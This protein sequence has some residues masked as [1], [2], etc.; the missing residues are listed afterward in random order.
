[1]RPDT[2]TDSL[3]TSG[4][5][6]AVS[7]PVRKAGRECVIRP[8]VHELITAGAEGRLT[9]ISAP[10]GAGKT[11]ALRSW[12][13]SGEYQGTVV[14]LT[15]SPTP[16]D[17]WRDLGAVTATAVGIPALEDDLPDDVIAWTLQGLLSG[18]PEPVLYA[19]DDLHLLGYGPELRLLGDF[20]SRVP[21]TVSI[22]FTCRRD[23]DLAL[24]R[25]RMYGELSEIRARELA[26]T[27]DEAAELFT[28]SGLHVEEAHVAAL[29]E[30]TEGWAAGL[31]F[32]AL[33]IKE[34]DDL[35][36]FI[37]KFGR[38]EGVVAEFL[39]DEVLARLS[40]EMRAFLFITAQPD[41]I[42][43]E[44]ADAMTGRTDSADILALLERENVFL[45]HL[46]E[47]GWYRY[48]ALFAA[49]LRADGRVHAPA[50]VKASHA[51]AARWLVEHGMLLAAAGH[52]IAAGDPDL[53]EH[54]VSSLWS[55][56]IGQDARATADDLLASIPGDSIGDRPNLALLAGW[57]R[58]ASGQLGEADAWFEIADKKGLDLPGYEFA[59]AL[60]SLAR[61]R[62]VGDVAGIDDA[63]SELESS[64]SI[65]RWGD[66][67]RRR[68]IV[69]CAR[70]AAAIWRNDFQLGIALLE[71]AL[72]DAR[73]LGLAGCEADASGMLAL[74]YALRG[75]LRRAERLAHAI[76][77]RV[78]RLRAG[79]SS[80][81]PALVALE[82]CAFEWDDDDCERWLERALDVST[83][84]RDE[85]GIACAIA[86]SAHALGRYGDETADDL[87][88]RLAGLAEPATAW[89]PLLGSSLRI[90]RSRLALGDQDPA[91]ARAAL[92]V[93]GGAAEETIAIA[94]VACAAGE[95]EEAEA[96]LD[97]VLSDRPEEL[98]T[99]AGVEARVLRALVA[100][101]QGRVDDAREWIEEALEVAEPEGV[102]GPFID[103]GASI[104]EPLRRTVRRGTAHRWLAAALL[105]RFEGREWERGAP[106]ELLIP[107]SEK[108]KVV[109]RYLPTLLSNEEIAGEMFVSVNTV[110]T[111]L[112]SIYRKLAV[113]QRRD[114]VRRARELR[115]LG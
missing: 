115:L 70:G 25:A 44:L 105:A 93:T 64:N 13:D 96:I 16:S 2:A 112:K 110:K 107:L 82:I 45:E 95:V 80:L 24:R 68:V 54:L 50:L 77:A 21:D 42:C 83:A 28:S 67:D 53:G 94:R 71:R 100:E 20:V 10:P 56:I 89:P 104:L 106:R 40:D 8:R 101:R 91:A 19:I 35:D 60:V 32:A 103:A 74:A 90:L 48:H 113:S 46:D 11:L 4:G 66:T 17:F 23:V 108:E 79:S 7:S 88:I 14:E 31:R 92:D 30:L 52:A 55:E 47:P 29:V 9:M 22:V 33:T 81:V 58:L 86:F 78:E 114:A 12:L 59:R 102:R 72:S 63:A 65:S 111:H 34:S 61:A 85:L 73:R 3:R 69:L 109:L 18:T 43:A 49:F 97:V 6:T 99:H 26:F 75:E 51:P 98:A 15:L 36:R 76:V 27:P 87:R 5:S 1:V 41:R 37:T 39:V 62:A 57:S 84:A 38:S